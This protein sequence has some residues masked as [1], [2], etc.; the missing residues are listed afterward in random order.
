MRGQVGDG[1]L[2]EVSEGQR[3]PES[4]ASSHMHSLMHACILL[5][6][7]QDITHHGNDIDQ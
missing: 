4:R 3:E 7:S 5:G 2:E 1:G 6:D